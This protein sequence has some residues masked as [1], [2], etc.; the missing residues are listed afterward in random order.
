M[1][2]DRPANKFEL[3]GI[4]DIFGRTVMKMYLM[5]QMNILLTILWKLK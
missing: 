1:S 5:K 2:K 4:D 3:K